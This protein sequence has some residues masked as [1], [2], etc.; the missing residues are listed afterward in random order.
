MC[1]LDGYFS[2]ISLLPDHICKVDFLSGSPCPSQELHGST[3][4]SSGFHLLDTLMVGQ[5]SIHPQVESIIRPSQG[6]HVKK[7]M[8]NQHSVKYS[9][10][11]RS[12]Q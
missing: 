8:Q 1:D 12:V 4:Y 10:C 7:S 9:G 2:G 6:T 3:G 11:E 5:C